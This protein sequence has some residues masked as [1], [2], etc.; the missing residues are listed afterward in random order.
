MQS[1]QPFWLEERNFLSNDGIENKA[2]EMKWKEINFK[3]QDMLKV[4]QR[5]LIENGTIMLD[6]YHACWKCIILINRIALNGNSFLTEHAFNLIFNAERQLK[7][8][9]FLFLNSNKR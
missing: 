3:V 1:N 7:Q 8:L 5:H 9:G 4:L 2:T 6:I